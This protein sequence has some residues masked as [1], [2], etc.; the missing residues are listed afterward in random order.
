MIIIINNAYNLRKTIIWPTRRPRRL[1]LILIECCF[2]IKRRLSARLVRGYR[3]GETL[4]TG[5]NHS[6]FMASTGFFFFFSPV[7]HYYLCSH[8]KLITYNVAAATVLLYCTERFDGTINTKNL[9]LK[10]KPRRERDETGCS[11]VACMYN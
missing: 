3:V 2:S 8:I 11:G 1:V 7:I 4:R 6:I 9:K 5:C 10:S